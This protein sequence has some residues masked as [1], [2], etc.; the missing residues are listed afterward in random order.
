MIP[1]SVISLCWYWLKKYFLAGLYETA[2]G[3]D[4]EVLSLQR[5]FGQWQ[6]DDSSEEHVDLKFY[7]YVEAVK[8]T[9]DNLVPAGQVLCFAL[10]HSYLQLKCTIFGYFDVNFALTISPR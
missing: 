9:G 4:S 8:L 6:E 1:L 5:K 10:C 3:F 7:E 2:S